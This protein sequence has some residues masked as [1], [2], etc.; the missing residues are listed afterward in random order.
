M[1]YPTTQIVS[2]T[3][4]SMLLIS[5][6][7]LSG[8]KGTND[9]DKNIF[10]LLD[11][12]VTN[13]QQALGKAQAARQEGKPDNA[14]Y[15]YVKA[16]QYNK[17]NITAMENIAAINEK[18][19][20]PELAIKV[21]HDILAIN[22]KHALANEKLG[23][24][25]LQN[26]HDSKA[27]EYLLQAVETDKKRWMSH[28]ALGVI[29]DL[30]GDNE[31]AIKHYESALAVAPANPMILNNVGY[32]F[33][34]SGNE[35]KAKNFFNQALN[36]D[37]LYKRAI[38]NLALIEIKNADFITAAALFNRIMSP[39]EAY[40]NIGY[41]AML[42]GQYSAAEEYLT[43]AINESPV[44]FP[45]AQ[46]NLKTLQSISEANGA[47]PPPVLK[48]NKTT[49]TSISIQPDI[50]AQNAAPVAVPQQNIKNSEATSSPKS[51]K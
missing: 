37:P 51:K 11:P 20:H 39:H 28:N 34:L 43:R 17:N 41:I 22:K 13:E 7:P 44:Y 1:A 4:L 15:Y 10:D 48:E 33:Y 47:Y 30:E 9:E 50:S 32:S 46:Q 12:T 45:K 31:K 3:F 2:L 24:Y 18:G 42:N 14:L 23:L 36:Y 6:S 27:K 38:H 49:D 16:L 26:G 29:A 19:K 5:C 21:Y 8:V 35:L 40:N 25:Y